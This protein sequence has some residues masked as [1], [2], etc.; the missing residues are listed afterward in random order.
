MDE[1]GA[2]GAPEP[3]ANPPPATEAPEPEVAPVGQKTTFSELT[4]EQAADVSETAMMIDQLSTTVSKRMSSIRRISFGPGERVV[5]D[6]TTL[7][8]IL[9]VSSRLKDLQ[10]KSRLSMSMLALAHESYKDKQV[11]KPNN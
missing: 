1:A 9:D 11:N 10:K 4:D 5:I 2:E 3:D 6:K 8:A 7:E